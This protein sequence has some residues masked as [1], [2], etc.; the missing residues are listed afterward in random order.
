MFPTSSQL[1]FFEQKNF[2]E[3]ETFLLQVD[4]QKLSLFNGGGEGGLSLCSPNISMD[5]WHN[6]SLGNVFDPPPPQFCWEKSAKEQFLNIFARFYQILTLISY[7][8]QDYFE[9]FFFYKNC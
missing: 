8:F 3:G 7:F 5:F 9:L 2:S 4:I 6:K 1:L